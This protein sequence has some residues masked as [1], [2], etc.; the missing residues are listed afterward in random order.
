MAE[1]DEKVTTT[2]PT[3][4]TGAVKPVKDDLPPAVTLAGLVEEYGAPGEQAYHAIAAA[5][6][7]GDMRLLAHS[8]DLDLVGLSGEIPTQEVKEFGVTKTQPV[9]GAISPRAAVAKI[10]ADLK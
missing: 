2:T 5:G 8:P 4:K 10:L 6:G 1:K 7:Y 9:P 3:P